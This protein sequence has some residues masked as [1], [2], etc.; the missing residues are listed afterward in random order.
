MTTI[1]VARTIEA[2][3]V[4]LAAI[5]FL[6]SATDIVWITSYERIFERLPA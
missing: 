6:A 3:A 1:N 5:I 4:G 2:I